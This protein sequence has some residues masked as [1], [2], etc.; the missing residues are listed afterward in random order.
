MKTFTSIIIS[1]VSFFIFSCSP[2]A[3][4]KVTDSKSVKTQKIVANPIEK[5]SSADFKQKITAD[6]VQLVDIRT[7]GEFNQ[8]HIENSITFDYYKRSFMSQMNT[9]DKSKPVFIYCRSGSRS[10]GASRKM[11]KAGFTK[12][13]DL[14]GG[15]N[16]WLRAGFKLTR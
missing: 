12:I 16:Y 15:I 9:L 4:T 8:G 3:Q 13:Y 11:K 10:A 14:K 5:L 6:K 7:L 1:I 2:K